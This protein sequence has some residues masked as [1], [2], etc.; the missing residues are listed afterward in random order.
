MT[1]V[2]LR[3]L[4]KSNKRLGLRNERANENKNA[5]VCC[6]CYV[7]R[8]IIVSGAGRSRNS[9]GPGIPKPKNGMLK[10]Y[11]DG[12]RQKVDWHKQQKDSQPLMVWQTVS[13]DNT[14]TYIVGRLGQHW[15]DMDKPS[16]PDEADLAAYQKLVG[17][18]V[19]SMVARYYEL[20][21]KI[22][23][24]SGG[25]APSKY[26]EI[27]TFHVRYN[28]VSEFRSAIGRVYDATVKTKWAVNY[29]WYEL[30]NG[31]DTGTY[32]LVLPRSTWADF[33]SKPDVKPFREM[34]K[35]AFGQA[36][37]DSIVD[38][39]DASVSSET[40]ETIQFRG[41]LSYMPGK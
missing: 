12:R 20:M 15:S 1:C 32:V 4:G 22:S 37:A 33:V 26:S 25:A 30:V 8:R 28:K 2:E 39:I 10:Q 9:C 23:N 14:G 6:G 29:E 35:E 16:V 34:L 3:L 5:V 17:G 38:R 24:G 36:E 13:G 11:E 7:A 18:Y 31:G 27:L 40:S 21:P 19:E 41:D